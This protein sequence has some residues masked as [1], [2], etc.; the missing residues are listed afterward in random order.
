MKRIPEGEE[1][2]A[3][4]MGMPANFTCAHVVMG[5]VAECTPASLCPVDIPWGTDKRPG[6]G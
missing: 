1:H 5:K 4:G 6:D 3:T 2:P